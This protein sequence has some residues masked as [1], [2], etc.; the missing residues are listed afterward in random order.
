MNTR[1]RKIA[2]PGAPI[3]ILL[4]DDEPMVLQA[5][6]RTLSPEGYRVLELSDP[7]QALDLVEREA[8]D[9]V[10]A[11]IHMPGLSGIDLVARLRK[12]FP[13]VVRLL[14]TGDGDLDPAIDAINRGEVFRYLTKPWQ[15]EGLRQTLRDAVGRLGEL[16][17]QISTLESDEQRAHLLAALEE[18]HPG[19]TNVPEGDTDHILSQAHL[20]AALL[21]DPEF[22][23]FWET[24]N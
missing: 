16:R 13:R 22:R 23:A 18:A 17:G 24:K 14:L 6:R 7:T 2:A 5:L 19:I 4:V 11:D 8:V 12:R 10:L 15:V 20:D 1:T 21:A 9:I 3:T